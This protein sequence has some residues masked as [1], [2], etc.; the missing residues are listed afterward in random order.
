MDVRIYPSTLTKREITIPTSKSLAHRSIICAALSDGVSTIRNVDLSVD[1]ETTINCMRAF[2]ATIEVVGKDVKVQGVKEYKCEEELWC[3][4][5]GSTLRFMI[6]IFSLVDKKVTLKGSSRLLQRPQSVYEEIFRSQNLSFIQNDDGIEIEGK[7]KAG[8]Y[9]IDG[10]ISSQFISGLLF[11]LPLLD[12]DSAIEIKPPFAS[13]SYVDLTIDMLNK[14]GVEVK[15]DSDL[16][17]SIRGNQKYIPQD[18]TVEADYS[19]LAFYAGLGAINGPL[20]CIGANSKSLQGDKEIIDIL[21]S[22]NVESKWEEDRITFMKSVITESVIDLENCPDLGPIL[23]MITSF[24]EG[25]THFKNTARL[26]IK[27]SDRALAMK[28]ELAKWGVNVEVVDNDA[29]VHGAKLSG[30]DI[31]FDAHNDH[32][33]VMALS[34]GATLAQD[35]VVI[36]NA[37]VI[38]KSYPR[39]FEDLMSLG[40]KV[41]V[42]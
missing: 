6:P 38:E 12:G 23:F 41:E 17:L 25:A 15:W 3:S 10:N 18:V 42:L 8:Q 14:F 31:E 1:I 39:F 7:L 29:W 30:K 20:T 5:S 9:I 22:M 40:I 13:R 2:G 4:E 37:H 21:S 28:A 36:R 34:I 16:V 11:V 24:S 33:I 26:K 27:E 32:R 35:A 19:Q